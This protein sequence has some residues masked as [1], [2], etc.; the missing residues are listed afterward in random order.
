MDPAD[1]TVRDSE[2]RQDDI[3]T[4]LERRLPDFLQAGLGRRLSALSPPM[5]EGGDGE[6]IVRPPNAAKAVARHVHAIA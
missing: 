1:A 4:L 6:V 2:F 3:R 5:V